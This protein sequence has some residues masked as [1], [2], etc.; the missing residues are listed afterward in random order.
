MSSSDF[1]DLHTS[2]GLDVVRA[3]LLA[4]L[5]TDP[6]AAEPPAP[7]VDD[8]RITLAQALERFALAMPDAKIWDAHQH[9]LLKQSAYK[10]LV[11]AGVFADWSAHDARKTVQQQDVAPLQ[12]A[13]QKEGAG[14]LS[15]ALERFVYLYPSDTVWDR[16]KMAVVGIRDL[17]HAIA[18]DFDAWLKHPQ[19]RQVDI[20]QLVFD[21]TQK[22]NASTHINMFRG[23]P[24]KPARN[25]NKCKNIRR[26][27]NL[28]CNEDPPVFDY[29]ANWLAYPLQHVGAKMDSAVMMHSSRQGSGK[30]FL[31]DG[32][33]R[34]IYGEYGAT[35]GQHQLESQYTDWRS[36]MLFGLF[37]EV[38]SRDQKY[39]HT[40]TIKHM[41]TG[42]THR[43]EKKYL[44]GW[45][46]A[47]HMNA[48]FL[49]NEIQPFPLDDSDRRMFV[50]WPERTL[51]LAVQKAVQAEVE[52]GGIEAFY[53]WLLARDLGEFN[54]RTPPPMTEA[55]ERLIDF[56]RAGWDTFYREWQRGALDVPFCTCLFSDLFDVY[57]AWATRTREK[58]LT[59]TRF[60]GFVSS[61]ADV[62]KRGDFRY[63]SGAGEKKGVVCVIGEPPEGQ[64]QKAWGGKCIDEFKKMMPNNVNA[65]DW[66]D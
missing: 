55:K 41:I 20:E 26:M 23:L 34:K 13:A 32:I 44:S 53:A 61:Q 16:K 54:P 64:T 58:S 63:L 66:P 5:D 45:E 38:L 7:P 10:L 39:S 62:K 50:V 48:V 12:A 11:G 56:G 65:G 36:K 9:R 14:G 60:V 25:D 33:V 3:Q 29:L 43:I 18:A 30:S 4:A 49:S 6:L 31:F 1:N 46:E 19:R 59:R 21:P 2:A 52:S 24:L 27:L 42:A 8:E 28:L 15:Q 40:G 17:R 57:C 35:L 22:A 47:N 51:P 37:E